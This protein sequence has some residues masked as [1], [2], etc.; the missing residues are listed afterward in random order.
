[1]A[2]YINWKASVNLVGNDLNKRQNDLGFLKM[3]MY[4]HILD[5]VLLCQKYAYEAIMRDILSL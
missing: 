5:S 1:M 4:D 3:Y 2:S